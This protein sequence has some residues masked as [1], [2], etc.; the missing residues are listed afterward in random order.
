MSISAIDCQMGSWGAFGRCSNCITG[1]CGVCR[2]T[3]VREVIKD[4]AYGGD[5]NCRRE[6]ETVMCTIPCRKK[7][8][9]DAFSSLAI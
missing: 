7:S 5:C 2:K 8:I 6:E 9:V 4:C 1:K 3:R